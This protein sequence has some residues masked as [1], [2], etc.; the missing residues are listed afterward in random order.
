MIFVQQLSLFIRSRSG[1]SPKDTDVCRI[2]DLAPINKEGLR[3]IE[4]EGV[5]LKAEAQSRFG[6]RFGCVLAA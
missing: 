1:T 6:L 3:L 5:Y 2:Q 4:A